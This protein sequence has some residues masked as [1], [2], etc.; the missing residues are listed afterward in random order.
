MRQTSKKADHIGRANRKA[1][2]CRATLRFRMKRLSAQ[3]VHAVCDI[4]SRNSIAMRGQG[5]K[6]EVS[7]QQKCPLEG[8]ITLNSDEAEEC[9][10]GWL[11]TGSG[12]ERCM[13]MDAW[14]Y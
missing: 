7:G 11:P 14:V 13:G 1:Q 5:D 2:L 12:A 6:N 3:V 10:T 8:W 9:R 4:S